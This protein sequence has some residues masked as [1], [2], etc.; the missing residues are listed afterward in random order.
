MKIFQ[1]SSNC[2][3]FNHMC[4][5][6]EG[7]HTHTVYTLFTC[8]HVYMFSHANNMFLLSVTLGMKEYLLK[9]KISHSTD[10]KFV[11]FRLSW[12]RH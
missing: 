3:D 8:V 12:Q 11:L 7:T 1:A 10:K 5:V 6:E 2:A 9:Q 4:P